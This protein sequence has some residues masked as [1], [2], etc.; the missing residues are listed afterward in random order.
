LL[1][2]VVVVILILVPRGGGAP[3]VPT[4]STS[5]PPAAKEAAATPPKA[6]AP[7]VSSNIKLVANT[8]KAD[9]NPG[10]N[11][12]IS[13]TITN[14]GPVACTM[15]VGSTVQEFRITSG[16]ELYWTSKDCQTGAVDAPTVL[17][18]NV[19]QS[20]TP[21][22]WDR[23]RSSKTTC[24]SDRNKVPAA[25]ASYHLQVVVGDIKSQGTKQFVLR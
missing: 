23:T 18:P 22:P 8:D 16:S 24:T 25:G 1:V 10:E 9:Y 2:V 19:A 3:A 11:P 5:T 15:N 20:T 7:C 4:A 12:M 17:E 6:G 13:F 14:I 21:I